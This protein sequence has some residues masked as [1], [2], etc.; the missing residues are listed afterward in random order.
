MIEKF[1]ENKRKHIN[2][3]QR[4][5]DEVEENNKYFW[6]LFFGSEKWYS[7]DPFSNT[8]KMPALIKVSNKKPEL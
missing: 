3:V 7:L 8:L 1:E 5:W 6:E 4:V 2:S